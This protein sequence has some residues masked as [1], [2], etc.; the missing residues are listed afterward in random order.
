MGRL[1]RAPAGVGVGRLAV[2]GAV[3]ACLLAMPPAPTHA[4]PKSAKAKKEQSG[5]RKA[6][7]IEISSWINTKPLRARDLEGT[8]RLVEFWTFDCVNCQNSVLAMREI[9]GLYAK[10]G[11]R[12]LGIHTPEFPHERD[13]SAVAAAVK[14]QGIGYPVG[15]DNDFAVFNGFKNKYWPAIFVVDREGIIRATHIGELHVG[16]RAWRNLC[17]SIERVLAMKK[18]P[19]RS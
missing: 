2:I 14:K 15:L 9:Y 12:V 11:L 1:R 17:A 18:E 3:A 8:P 10:Q 16:T 5:R 19:R 13:S 4:K 7:P 6:P